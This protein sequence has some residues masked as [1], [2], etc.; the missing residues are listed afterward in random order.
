MGRVVAETSKNYLNAF[1]KINRSSHIQSMVKSNTLKKSSF[2]RIPDLLLSNKVLITKKSKEKFKDNIS[3][4]VKINGKIY[5]C[6]YEVKKRISKNICLSN[7]S[8]FPCK[9]IAQGRISGRFF[10]YDNKGRISVY[11]GLKALI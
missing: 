1:F 9:N 3:K 8:D 4:I 6:I 11:I 7:F 5:L 2:S 10:I